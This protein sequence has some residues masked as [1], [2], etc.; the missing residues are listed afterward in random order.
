MVELQFEIVIAAERDLVF[1]TLADIAAYP[2]W[3][4]PSPTFGTIRDVQPTPPQLGTTYTDAVQGPPMRGEIIVFERPY[5]IGFRQMTHIGLA[6]IRF[7]MTVESL[8]TLTEQANGTHI[9]RDYQL[10]TQGLLRFLEGRIVRMGATENER[11][12][13]TLKQHLENTSEP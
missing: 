5:Q 13:A 6:F 9:R 7:A 11:I 8:Y 3:L 10:E 4:P 12:L 2:D 1:E